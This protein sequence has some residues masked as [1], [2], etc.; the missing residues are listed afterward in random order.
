M[1]MELLKIQFADGI[2]TIS[3]NRPDKKN[4]LTPETMAALG[5]ALE[6]C[7]GDG[8][9]VVI[10]KGEGGNFCS[11]AMLD[12][13]ALQGGFDVTQYLKEGVNPVVRL[14]RS[15]PVPVIAQV[16]GVCVGLG[17]SLALACDLLF[18]AE[19][20]TFSQ[21]FTRIGLASD[22]GGAYLLAQTVGPRKAFELIST[23]ANISAEQAAAW[24][25]A[26][27]VMKPEMLNA[28]VEAMAARLASG[29]SVAI[30]CVKQ[31]LQANTLDEAL[32]MEAENQG[33]CFKTKDFVEGVMAF[34]QKRSPQFTGQ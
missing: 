17:F 34:I 31:N 6:A 15:L 26:N 16:E 24:G 14:M 32:E 8:T 21:I 22:G 28:T 5:S 7:L 27:H 33:K 4:P 29:P 25:I 13:G 3:F 2:K 30:G 23:N 9:K 20:A 11:G 1:T 10:L 18:A 19:G 12:P